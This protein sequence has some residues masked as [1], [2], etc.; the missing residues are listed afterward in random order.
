[1]PRLINSNALYGSY[2]SLVARIQ[3]A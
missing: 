2:D 3:A 1:M